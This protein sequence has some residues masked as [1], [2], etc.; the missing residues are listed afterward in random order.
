MPG[1]G[2]D[3]MRSP[4]GVFGI[5]I[6]LLLFVG[7]LDYITGPEVGFF[8]FYFIP[9]AFISWY[10]AVSW[11]LCFSALASCNFPRYLAVFFPLY[12]AGSHSLSALGTGVSQLTTL[13]KT[14]VGG[15]GQINL[16][17]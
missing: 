9:L 5:T 6:C 15:S 4:Y 1:V 17:Y 13:P 16:S 8:V 2:I 14:N 11:S 3:A 7:W 12:M 10:G